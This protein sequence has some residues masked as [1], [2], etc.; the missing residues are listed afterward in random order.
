MSEPARDSFRAI[1]EAVFAL[2]YRGALPDD[3]E[4]FCLPRSA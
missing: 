3:E 4:P 1:I 2:A